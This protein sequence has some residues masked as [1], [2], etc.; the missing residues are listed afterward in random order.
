MKNKF[1]SE[2]RLFIS[3][4]NHAK[5][6]I[7]ALL[8][9]ILFA[10][11]FIRLIEVW[12]N[13][14]DYS[15]GFF[16]LPISLYMVWIKRQKLSILNKD[17][18]WVGFLVLLLSLMTYLVAYTIKFNTMVYLSMFFIII[19]IVLFLAGWQVMKE[20]LLPVFFLLF[21]FPIPNSY[22]IMITNPLKLM[23]TE[24][25]AQLIGLLGI[26]VYQEG[27]LLFMAHYQFEIAEACSGVRSLNSYL[28]L[29]FVFVVICKKL[30]TKMILIISTVPLA[31]GVNIIRVTVTGILAIFFGEK[32]AQGFFH[33]FT[34][35]IL[36][37]IG[38]V[39]LYLEYYFI[40]GKSAKD[41]F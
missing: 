32:V 3:P 31:I 29:G 24:I 9:I 10:P 27:N 11:A 21:M 39:V 41:G 19:G 23:I 38:L 22:Y 14:P 37:I 26:P 20:L 15:H 35:F 18:S 28:M 1:I 12:Y 30:L 33:E 8:A 34:G 5:A 40:E 17:I 4:G 25:S 7:V 6:I 2:L 16:V 13:D 36:F